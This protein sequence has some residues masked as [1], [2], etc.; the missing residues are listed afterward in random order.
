MASSAATGY[1]NVAYFVNW[2][3]Y[4]RNFNPQDL[5]GQELTRSLYAFA[6]IRPETGEVYLTDTW[7]DTDKHY[8]ADSWNNVGT[9][10]F[11]CAKLMRQLNDYSAQYANNQH[12]LLTVASPAGP[13]NYNKM[14]LDAMDKC[15]DFRNLMAYD[16]SSS[17]DTNAS[18]DANFC[19]SP[20]NPSSTP[21]STKKALDEYV[22]AGVPANKI[23]LGMPLYGRSFTQ[24]NGPGKAFQGVGQGTWEAGVYD[25]KALPQAGAKVTEDLDLVVSW[26]Y[27]AA[28]RGMIS[29]DTPAI[30]A[31]K[32]Q[33]VRQQGLGGAMW[34]ESLSD[35]GADGL[36]STR[37]LFTVL[38]ESIRIKDL[39]QSEGLK[40][41]MEE[42]FEDEYPTKPA[43]P[44]LNQLDKQ[45]RC[46]A[47]L[48]C[49][50]KHGAALYKSPSCEEH[51]VC[52]NHQSSPCLAKHN[53][54]PGQKHRAKDDTKITKNMALEV[55]ISSTERLVEE[56]LGKNILANEKPEETDAGK[57]LLSIGDLDNE[58]P[59]KAI[60]KE[61][62][63]K[64]KS[65]KDVKYPWVDDSS[66]DQGSSSSDESEWEDNVVNGEGMN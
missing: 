51:F 61:T 16:Y 31:K 43:W 25:Y 24:T 30:I 36:I 15:L 49:R 34:W 6:N 48:G 26:S 63:G 27:D 39:E 7:S 3:I 46:F 18:H 22:S 60:A 11:G 20:S 23:V 10:V 12:L 8:H 62:E 44:Y 13:A 42:L 28:K 41:E 21:F 53:H 38:D 4:G 2:A 29:Y 47:K 45:D 50:F 32:A 56:D 40:S 58:R 52:K 5:P 1:K 57:R 14:N 55:E 9:N 65:V 37:V 33:L 66:Y 35:K 19:P 54:V 64:E 59:P 17:S